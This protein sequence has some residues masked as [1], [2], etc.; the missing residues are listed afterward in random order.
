M[1]IPF[2]TK[3]TPS[4]SAITT[5]LGTVPDFT[6]AELDAL[7]SA[8]HGVPA[9]TCAAIGKEYFLAFLQA[10]VP[11]KCLNLFG[12]LGIRPTSG[13]KETGT[14]DFHNATDIN[15]D[16]AVVYLTDAIRELRDTSTIQNI[17]H[18]GPGDPHLEIIENMVNGALNSYTP[19]QMVRISGEHL[20]FERAA[21]IIPAGNVGAFIQPAAGGAWTHLTTYGNLSDATVEVLIPAAITGQQRLKIVNGRTLEGISGTTIG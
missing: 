8:K 6:Q 5:K 14:D 7:V 9:A 21:A 3:P 20:S 17:G 2:I 16:L 11:T 1:N 10:P 18:D 4:G 13:G 15:F 19:G 12:L